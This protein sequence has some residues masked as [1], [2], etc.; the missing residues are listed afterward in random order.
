MRLIL[1]CPEKKRLTDEFSDALMW[2][3]SVTSKELGAVQRGELINTGYDAEIQ[4]AIKMRDEYKKLLSKHVT[5]H[6]C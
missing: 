3:L 2:I 6:G 4:Q 1:I 5:E